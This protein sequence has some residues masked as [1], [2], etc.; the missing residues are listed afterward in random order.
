MHKHFTEEEPI[1]PI[2]FESYSASLVVKEMEIKS[3]IA[4][5]FIPIQVAK[6]N[7]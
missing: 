5:H 1:K 7:I 3:T 6:L 4:Y 2:T